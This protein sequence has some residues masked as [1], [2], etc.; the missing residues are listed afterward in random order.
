MFSKAELYTNVG[1]K[2]SKKR[3]GSLIIDIPDKND[4]TKSK[5]YAKIILYKCTP[6]HINFTMSTIQK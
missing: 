2:S 4:Q 1:W 6:R 3:P 5:K